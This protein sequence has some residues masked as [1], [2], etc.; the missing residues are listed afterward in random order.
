MSSAQ[1]GRMQEI[2]ASDIEPDVVRGIKEHVC[3]LLKTDHIDAF[4][5]AW[6]EL[7]NAVKAT[8]MREA[9]SLFLTLQPNEHA[10]HLPPR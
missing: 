1:P 5:R 9:K 6:A 10:G 3:Q 4:H 8:R 7:E 2:I